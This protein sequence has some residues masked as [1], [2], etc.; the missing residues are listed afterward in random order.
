VLR[1]QADGRIGNISV[2]KIGGFNKRQG[3]ALP[4]Q[5]F[6]FVFCSDLS[7]LFK[8]AKLGQLI[9]RKIIKIVAT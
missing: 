3:E 6:L 5:I 8:R 2:A 9:L 1:E 7:L 4:P